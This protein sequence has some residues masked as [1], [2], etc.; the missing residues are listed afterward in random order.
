MRSFRSNSIHRGERGTSVVTAL[1]LVMIAIGL[2]AAIL[3]TITSRAELTRSSRA[4]SIALEIADSGLA[5]ARAEL[6]VNRDLDGNGLGNAAG[7]V[8]NGP[9]SVKCK[10]LDATHY[11][12]TSTGRYDGAYRTIASMVEVT[13]SSESVFAQGLFGDQLVA[14]GAS[15]TVDSFD[16]D[17]GPYVTQA[18]QTDA[19]GRTFARAGASVGSNGPVSLLGGSTIFGDASPGVGEVVTATGGARVEGQSAP[20]DEPLLLPLIDPQDYQD[21]DLHRRAGADA[22]DPSLPA[23]HPAND[24]SRVVAVGAVTIADGDLTVDHGGIATLPSGVY[25]VNSIR[26]LNGGVL[27]VTG[28]VRLYIAHTLDAAGGAIENVSQKPST[29]QIYGLGDDAVNPLHVLKVSAAHGVYAAIYAPKTS[30][31]IS[32]RGHFYGAA[33]ARQIV[34]MGANS[35]HFDESMKKLP[36]ATKPRTVKQISWRRVATL[37]EEMGF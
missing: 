10:K 37:I 21:A 15:T 25:H 26:L 19:A 4:A 3:T 5:A 1:L 17:E 33:V 30:L 20:R 16:S 7:V 8:S 27:K 34:E 31:Q 13:D 12:L 24:L 11:R 28:E 29:L 9:Y 23:P 6:L 18:T 36:G 35:L 22:D 14:F 32:G 2:S